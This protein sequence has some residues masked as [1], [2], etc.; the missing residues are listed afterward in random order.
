MERL[1]EGFTNDGWNY[2]D[3][4][5]INACYR[6]PP[7]CISLMR[8]IVVDVEY[9]R[10]VAQGDMHMEEEDGTKEDREYED[11]FD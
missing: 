9:V 2:L 11:D 4:N 5:L 10:E 8:M 7:K 3:D 1:L 6:S